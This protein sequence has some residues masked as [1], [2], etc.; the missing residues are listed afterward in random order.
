ME[1]SKHFV[2]FHKGTF[3]LLAASLMIL[4]GF[5]SETFTPP[6]AA[7]QAEYDIK[8]N[9]NNYGTKGYIQ[10]TFSSFFWPT[11]SKFFKRK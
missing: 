5:Q 2:R 11:T 8:Y 9:P 3:V 4:T 7:I 10:T 6:T 1:L